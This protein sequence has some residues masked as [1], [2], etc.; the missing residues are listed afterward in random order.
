MM[1]PQTGF[2]VEGE[3]AVFKGKG[4]SEREVDR[5]FCR[6]CGSSVFATAEVVPGRILIAAGTLDNTGNFRPSK[7]NYTVSRTHWDVPY[8]ASDRAGA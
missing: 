5:H 1:V 7:S 3:T 8:S 2:A 4:D 6:V